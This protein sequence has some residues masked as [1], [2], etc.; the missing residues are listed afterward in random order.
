L[1]IHYCLAPCL[2]TAPARVGLIARE[3]FPEL[4]Y[5]VGADLCPSVATSPV[6]A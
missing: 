6:E 3:L 5:Q 4:T 2:A 1:G